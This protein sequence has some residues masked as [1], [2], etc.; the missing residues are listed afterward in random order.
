M[1][2]QVAVALRGQIYDEIPV[3]PADWPMDVLVMADDMICRH[4]A[5]WELA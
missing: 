3:G 4:K 2:M 1:V 5:A